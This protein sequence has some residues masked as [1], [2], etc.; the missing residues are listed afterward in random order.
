[1]ARTFEPGETVRVVDLIPYPG[2]NTPGPDGNPVWVEP[3]F[4]VTQRLASVLPDGK[5]IQSPS[6]D[7]AIPIDEKT[8]F[9]FDEEEQANAAAQK[10]IEQF[11]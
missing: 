3:S 6:G 4:V 11:R 2:Y 7:E 10:L 1:M 9:H 8:V 5:S